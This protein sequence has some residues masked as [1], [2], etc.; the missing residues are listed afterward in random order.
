M[1][2]LGCLFMLIFGVVLVVL[3]AGWKIVSALFGL[4]GNPFVTF[5]T[6]KDLHQNVKNM[7]DD[8]SA[9]TPHSDLHEE[10]YHDETSQQ[11]TDT[12][13]PGATKIIPDDEGEY[14]SY[15]D[16]KENK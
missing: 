11:H 10:T 4:R 12:T 1:K 9:R 16:V 5:K 14:V 7:Q 8:M 2:V 15:E 13:S 3:I 6:V